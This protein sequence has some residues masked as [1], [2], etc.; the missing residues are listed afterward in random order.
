[1]DV[2]YDFMFSLDIIILR[3]IIW[4]LFM[5]SIFMAT[6]VFDFF[7][8]LVD[9]I[10]IAHISFCAITILH[11]LKNFHINFK[12]FNNINIL[13]DYCFSPTRLLLL[14]HTYASLS[15]PLLSHNPPTSFLS[16]LRIHFQLPLTKPTFRP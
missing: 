11:A 13:S 3:Y 15:S 1:L 7:F 16:V 8:L 4:M 10:K 6:L 5:I 12:I 9:F 2:L 14:S